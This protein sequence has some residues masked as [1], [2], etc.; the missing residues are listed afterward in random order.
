MA[1]RLGRKEKSVFSRARFPPAA[2]QFDT[3]VQ[4]FPRCSSSRTTTRSRLGAELIV[5]KNQGSGGT[6]GRQSFLAWKSRRLLGRAAED[7]V[8][9]DALAEGG[10]GRGGVWR[11]P[12]PGRREEI[13]REGENLLVPRT[14]LGQWEPK[15]AAG[16]S[17]GIF[18]IPG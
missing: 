15:K 5:H 8:A 3:P 7:E 4:N 14:P 18:L 16:R 2:L 1:L 10:F 13:R 17:S 12:A 9:S 11:R 6:A